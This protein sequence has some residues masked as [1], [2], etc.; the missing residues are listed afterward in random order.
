MKSSYTF[1]CPACGDARSYAPDP[2][3]HVVCIRRERRNPEGRV[4]A[5]ACPVGT[6]MG[7][8]AIGE[9]R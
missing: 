4:V 3:E 2:G 6:L 1:R 8:E 9:G 5:P 7:V